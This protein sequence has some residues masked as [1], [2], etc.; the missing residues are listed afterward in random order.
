MPRI[1]FLAV[2]SEKS[3]GSNVE[4]ILAFT[5]DDFIIHYIIS[6]GPVSSIIWKHSEQILNQN[7]HVH[8]NSTHLYITNLS[9]SDSGQYKVEVLNVL[10]NVSSEIHLIVH[11]LTSSTP[12]ASLQKLDTNQHS[13]L[14]PV[15]SKGSGP[16]L[17]FDRSPTVKSPMGTVICYTYSVL[18]YLFSIADANIFQKSKVFQSLII[19][20]LF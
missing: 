14:S 5:G 11:S 16:K 13:T 10:G 19:T 9:A 8:Y 1:A 12:T 7:H 20:N 15:I 4:T 3:V 2:Q 17:S 18:V 6:G